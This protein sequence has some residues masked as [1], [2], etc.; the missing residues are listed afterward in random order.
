MALENI[1]EVFRENLPSLLTDPA[2]LGQYA[3]VNSEGIAGLYPT[4]ESAVTAGDETFG[5]Q[6]FL[7]QEVVEREIPKYF[8]R[9]IQCHS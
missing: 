6:P 4:F 7:V 1:M 2:N 3:L 9:N 8:S 5:F